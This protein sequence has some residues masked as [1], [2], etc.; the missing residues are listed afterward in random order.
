ML[1][2]LKSSEMESW[3]KDNEGMLQ[4]YLEEHVKKLKWNSKIK[5]EV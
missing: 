2:E 1:D 5:G 4:E 3:A